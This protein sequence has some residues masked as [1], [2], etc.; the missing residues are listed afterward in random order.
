MAYIGQPFRG[1]WNPFDKGRNRE[2]L[3]VAA[4]V[5]ASVFVAAWCAM[6]RAFARRTRAPRPL[7]E[8]AEVAYAQRRL[9]TVPLALP[10]GVDDDSVP[11]ADMAAFWIAYPNR[12]ALMLST[13]RE[14]VKEDL[15]S[16]PFALAAF[17][18]AHCVLVVTT[19]PRSAHCGLLPR[20]R[21][22]A[23]RDVNGVLHLALSNGASWQQTFPLRCVRDAVAVL[24]VLRDAS[25]YKTLCV[26]NSRAAWASATQVLRCVTSKD[27]DQL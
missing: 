1:M 22:F 5:G 8:D 16:P 17:F 6:R 21:V 3:A 10:V 24:N 15:N 19:S 20:S 14:L 27:V 25:D 18:D 7:R 2:G 26:C 12:H 13:P 9:L 11:E 23:V 4:A